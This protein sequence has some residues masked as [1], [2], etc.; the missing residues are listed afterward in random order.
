MDEGRDELWGKATR[1][2]RTYLG[3]WDDHF[4]RDARD[5]LAQEAA[6]AFW[7][8]ARGRP[9]RL[10]LR[11]AM[12]TIAWRIRGRALQ[13]ARRG[14]VVAEGDADAWPQDFDEEPPRVRV[15][16]VLVPC[17][18]LLPRLQ[19]LLARLSS[20]NQRIVLAFYEGCTCAELAVRLGLS[21]EA[22]KVRLHR[23]RVILRRRLEEMTRAAGRF[24]R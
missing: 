4:T 10:P 19:R 7:R 5:D 14:G 12:Q 8:W 24:E 17:D 15:D 9:G 20:T 6:L 23:S 1:L 16:G 18:W 21:E 22:V 11:T 3:R 13:N 2:A